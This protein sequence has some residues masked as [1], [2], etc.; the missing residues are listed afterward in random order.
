MSAIFTLNDNNLR[1]MTEADLDRIMEIELS[2]YPHPWTR[3]IFTDC[4]RV[5]Y[6]CWVLED[7]VNIIGYAV[8]SI[9]VDEVHLLN[10]SI[11]LSHQNQ[12]L[13]RQ[14][15]I[16]MCDVAKQYNAES[17]LLEVRPS[18]YAAV[19]LY[20]SIGFN[21]IGVRKNYYPSSNGKR[22]DALIMAMALF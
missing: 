13:G 8:L 16:Q 7:D 1:P 3:G 15:I 12:G 6:K 21:E 5:G 22:E 9:A 20:N 10:V 4:I 18:N 19:Y 17:M 2:V 14:L 11:D